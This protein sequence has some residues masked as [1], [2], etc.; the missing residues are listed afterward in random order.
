[1]SE[2]EVLGDVVVSAERA[3]EQARVYGHGVDRE[4]ALLV[5]HGTLHLL[6]YTDTSPPEAARMRRRQRTLLEA[7]MSGARA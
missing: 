7:F 5:I 4:L 6:G 2:G 3:V 1:M